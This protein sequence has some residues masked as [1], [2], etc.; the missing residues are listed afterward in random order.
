MDAFGVHRATGKAAGGDTAGQD[1]PA[2]AQRDG[3][4]TVRAAA[5]RRGMRSRCATPVRP[6]IV[7]GAGH[8]LE[9]YGQPPS[10][11]GRGAQFLLAPG[12]AVGTLGARIDNGRLT[13][14]GVLDDTGSLQPLPTDQAADLAAVPADGHPHTRRIGDRGDY[15]MLA[16]RMPDGDV[17]M[18]GLPLA[19]VQTTLWQNAAVE[20]AVAGAALALTTAIGAVIVRRALRPLRRVAATATRVSTLPLERGEVALVERVTEGDTDPRTGVG[21]VGAALNRLLDHVAA[22]N[23][24]QASE[25]RVRQFVADASHELRTPLAAIRGYAEVTRRSRESAPADLAHAMGRVESEATRMTTLVEDLLLLARLDSGRPLR[26]EPVDP[27]LVV[28]AVSDASAAGRDHHWTLDLPDEPLIVTGD[29]ERLHQVAANLLAN[30]RAHTPAGTTRLTT[31][32]ATVDLA[33]LDDGPGIAPELLP[34]VFERFARGS[35]P[36]PA[37]QAARDSAWPS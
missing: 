31:S 17:L 11:E 36:V 34:N 6:V 12:H 10:R 22:L 27:P 7:V 5:H 37:R 24:R 9:G 1:E 35:A 3:L 16:T 29:A 19:S 25:S 28:D 21:Q 20:L 13:A 26:A 15:R 33:V 30:A 8:D 2:V 14:G 23:A 18:T 32:A 4:T